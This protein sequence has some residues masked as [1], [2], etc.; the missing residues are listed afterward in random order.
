[1]HH[2]YSVVDHMAVE[3]VIVG[4][5]IP[6]HGKKL[7]LF[8]KGLT[9]QKKYTLLQFNNNGEAVEKTNFDELH[10]RMNIEMERLEVKYAEPYFITI[11]G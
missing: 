9:D 8:E 6:H 11:E 1:M 5:S 10:H 7:V 4:Q 2:K 3:S